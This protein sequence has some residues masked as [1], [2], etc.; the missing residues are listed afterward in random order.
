MNDEAVYG[1]APAT[2]GLLKYRYI[3]D[4]NHYSLLT[5]TFL[6]SQIG[7]NAKIQLIYITF[8]EGSLNPS[9]SLLIVTNCNLELTYL[10]MKI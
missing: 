8:Q 3:I 1:T 9:I 7:Q 6:K 10:R 5:N 2:P 4:T